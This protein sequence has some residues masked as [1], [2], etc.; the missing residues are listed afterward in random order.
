MIATL[1]LELRGQGYQNIIVSGDKDLAQLLRGNDLWWD[2]A[3]NQRL[4]STGVVDKFGVPPEIIQ[5]YLG[6]CGDVVDNIPGVP[7]VGPKTASVLLQSYG[8]VEGVYQNLDA[9][10]NLSLRGA[11]TLAAKL[12]PHQEQAMLSKQLATVAYDAPIETNDRALK[13]Q[14]AE[15]GVLEEISQIIGGRGDGLFRRLVESSRNL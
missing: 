6:L 3:R 12:R 9:I 4:D 2:F 14:A 1:A 8:S 15:V 5:D 11:K 13:R 10:R 7:G